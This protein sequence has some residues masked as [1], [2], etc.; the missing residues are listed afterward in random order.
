VADGH[1]NTESTNM[2]KIALTLAAI[3]A[4]STVAL[5]NSKRTEDPRDL[6]PNNGSAATV[7]DSAA[8]SAP[9]GDVHAPTAFERVMQNIEGHYESR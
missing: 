1:G 9:A 4:L 3:A 7:V 2:K 5:A 6:K 8:F